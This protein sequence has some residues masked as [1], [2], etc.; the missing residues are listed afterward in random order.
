MKG[1]DLSKPLIQGRNLLVTQHRPL[2]LLSRKHVAPVSPRIHDEEGDIAVSE[3]IVMF[4]L[5]PS[6]RVRCTVVQLP[7]IGGVR[8]REGVI[9]QPSEV[10]DNL[11]VIVDVEPEKSEYTSQGKQK[12]SYI[13][14]IIT[15]S[16]R[17][18]KKETVLTHANVHKPFGS[19]GSGMS[20]CRASGMPPGRHP[21]RLVH[22]RTQSRLRR[23]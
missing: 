11:V 16:V 15:E 12:R 5:V 22:L 13:A 6:I 21:T 7:C 18:V 19:S 9:A 14:R 17:F 2:I 1:A 10:V 8:I 23:S 20:S 3:V 4:A